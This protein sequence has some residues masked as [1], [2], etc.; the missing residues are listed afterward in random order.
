MKKARSPRIVVAFALVLSICMPAQAGVFRAYLSSAGADTNPCSV[1]SPCRLLPAALA[2]VNDGG[3]IWILDSANYNSAPVVIGK[4]VTI[5][6]I[7]GA[8]GSLVSTTAT[9]AVV[10]VN[11]ANAMVTLR[12]LVIVPFTNPWD[13]VTMTLGSSLTIDRCTISG[14][15]N[16]AISVTTPGFLRVLDTVVVNTNVGV[17]VENGATGQVAGSKLVGIT[18][19]GVYAFGNNHPNTTTRINVSDSIIQGTDRFLGNGVSADSGDSTVQTSLSVSRSTITNIGIA[20]L[21]G[22]SAGAVPVLTVG[23]S[24][25]MH[26]GTGMQQTGTGVMNTMGDNAVVDNVF[27]SLGTITPNTRM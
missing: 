8:V 23:S 18:A 17:V 13:G 26:N 2:A 10:T 11:A 22:G 16:R 19:V 25:L 1:A 12:N 27:N 14:M 21:V 5:L 3:E 20:A 15:S 9:T 4:S 24:T 6:A 7:P